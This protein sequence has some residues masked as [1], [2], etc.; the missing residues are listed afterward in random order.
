MQPDGCMYR[1]VFWSSILHLPCHQVFKPPNPWTMAVLGVLVEMHSL[2]NVKVGS[3]PHIQKLY[4]C[5]S[6]LLSS[7]TPCFPSAQ[8]EVRSWSLVQELV[9]RIEGKTDQ[10]TPCVFTLWFLCDF[11]ICR[12]S[13]RMWRWRVS[14]PTQRSCDGSRNSHLQLK[15]LLLPSSINPLSITRT[16]TWRLWLGWRTTCR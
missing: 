8:S 13:F 1:K 12:L 5:M 6:R 4:S 9:C 7:T 3:N 11:V 15:A 2:P 14:C 16:S 10:K